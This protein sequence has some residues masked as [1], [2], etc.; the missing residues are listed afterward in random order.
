MTKTKLKIYSGLI[1]GITFSCLFTNPT[2]AASFSLDK[3]LVGLGRQEISVLLDSEGQEINAVSLTLKF[4]AGEIFVKNLSDA[5]SIISLWIDKPSFSEKE[6]EIHFSGI[7]P[8]GYNSAHGLLVKIN[9]ETDFS[10]NVVFGFKDAT[11]L[12]N[13]GLGTEAKILG[14]PL[15]LT[16]SASVA[17]TTPERASLLPPENFK[18]EIISDPGLYG[19]KWALIFST[20]DKGSGVDYYEVLES[21]GT[22]GP[23]KNAESPYLLEDQ[24]LSSDVFVRAVAKDGSFIIVKIPSKNIPLS[25]KKYYSLLVVLLLLIVGAVIYRNRRSAKRLPYEK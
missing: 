20:T 2:L 15:N 25:F 9:F 23:W 14:T 12:L 17:T 24:N 19:G 5:N 4:S 3:N 8:G 22:I 7:I 10:K 6:G 1:I 13:N 11:V 21:G 18:P 16:V